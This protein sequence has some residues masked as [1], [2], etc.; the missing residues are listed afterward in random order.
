MQF[1]RCPV[2]TFTPAAL[3]VLRDHQELFSAF[4][5]HTVPVEEAE[6]YYKLFEQNKIAKTVFS[7]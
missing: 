1:G 6:E 2:H 3:Q 7:F 4:I 5:E